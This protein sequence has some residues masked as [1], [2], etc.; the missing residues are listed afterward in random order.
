MDYSKALELKQQGIELREIMKQLNI[1]MNY[2]AFQ[3]GLLRF[4]NSLDSKPT[5]DI[6]EELL[7]ALNK[8]NNLRELSD[9][10]KSSERVITAYIEDLKEEGYNIIEFENKFRLSKDIILTDN[11]HEEDWQGNKIIKFGIVSDTHLCNKWQQLTFLNSLY[12]IFEHEGINTVY[13]AGDISDGYYKNRPSHIYELI[14]GI[15]GADAQAEY[16][17]DK[18]PKR[19]GVVTKFITGNHDDTH[20]MNGGVNIGKIIARQ[21]E[22]MI[23][24]GMNNAKINLTPNCVLELNHPGDGAAYALSYT[25][26][27]LIDSMSGG[28]KPNILING[29][30]HKYMYLFYRNIHAFEAGTIEAQT[31]FMKG[32]KIAAHLGGS[33]IEVH[34]NE[35]GTI[36]RCK[37]EFIPLY[38]PLENDY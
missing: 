4:E 20:I 21:R 15:A 31:P 6:K 24:L 9:K 8:E 7:K 30:H 22:D 5:L 12:D 10:L 16:I 3:R 35:E 23:Y 17:I 34:V 33:I 28:D 29:H 25:L 38:R 32:K 26:Q 1:S 27:K 36:T 19:K 14:P 2:K 11:R 18:Y 13:H 37:G